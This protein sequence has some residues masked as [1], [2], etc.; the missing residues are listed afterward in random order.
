[1]EVTD[2]S[3]TTP[4]GEFDTQPPSIAHLYKVAGLFLENRS[5]V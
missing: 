3:R 5:E 2:E 1:M 4:S